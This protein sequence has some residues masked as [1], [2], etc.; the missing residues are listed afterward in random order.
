MVCPVDIKCAGRFSLTFS[1]LDLA[2]LQS[3]L[4]G[5]ND[6]GELLR[7]LINRIDRHPAQWPSLSGTVRIG[8][9][10]AG[11]LVLHDTV[12]AL[13]ISGNTMKISSLTGRVANGAMHVSGTLDASGSEPDYQLNVQVTNAAPSAFAGIFDEHWGSGAANV[14]AQLEMSG[15]DTED[16]AKSAT[17]TVRWD[18]SKGGLASDD[19]LPVAA[20]PFAHFDQWNAEGT[21]GDRNIVITHSLLDRGLEAIPLTGTISFDRELDLKGGSPAHLFSVTGTLQ[22][23][24]AKTVTE[25]VAN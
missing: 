6:G 9:L 2:A 8:A 11:K 20:Q 22:H 25:E 16:L 1:T 18:W 15:Y 21:I 12:G 5:T 14:S 13:D 10:S 23:P 17:G 3:S 19:P 4:L 7:E 24:E